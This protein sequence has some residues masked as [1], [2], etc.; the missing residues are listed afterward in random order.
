[1]SLVR[2]II[3]SVSLSALIIPCFT[4]AEPSFAQHLS[5]AEL[6]Q[7]LEIKQNKIDALEKDRK[8]VRLE[9]GAVSGAFCFLL[10]YCLAKWRNRGI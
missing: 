6:I 4:R 8:W 9:A 3:L 1:M 2:K 10:G 7:L 5:H